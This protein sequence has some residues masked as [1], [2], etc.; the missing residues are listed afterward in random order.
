MARSRTVFSPFALDIFYRVPKFC[1]GKGVSDKTP[2]SRAPQT[3]SLRSKVSPDQNLHFRVTFP[4][5]I[6]VLCAGQNL[7]IAIGPRWL[8]CGAVLDKRNVIGKGG[9]K[10]EPDH[11]GFQRCLSGIFA[12]SG[13]TF[14]KPPAGKVSVGSFGKDANAG[15][16]PWRGN[17]LGG[18]TDS[19]F[20]VGPARR[21]GRGQKL[22]HLGP[23][24]C[25]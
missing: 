25:P 21:R 23:P 6:W 1:V 11:L 10:D 7:V 18:Y 20:D 14:R 24:E 15:K 2:G 17:V 5:W 22:C 3:S 8:S 16:R 9:A 12:T 19:C 13:R 4:N